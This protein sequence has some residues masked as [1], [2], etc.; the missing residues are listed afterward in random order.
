MALLPVSK[1]LE[2]LLDSAEILSSETVPIGEAAGRVLAEPVQ[3][4]RTQPPFP[5]SAMDGY[6]VRADDLKTIPTDLTVIGEAPAGHGFNGSVGSGEAVRIFTGAPVPDGADAILIQENAENA[7]TNRISAQTE[8][9]EGQHVR[10]AGLDFAKGEDLAEP[11]RLLDAAMLSL[12]AAANHAELNVV[13]RPRVA[14]LATGDELLPPGS[15]P[16]PDQIIASN[17]YGVAAIAAAAGAQTDDLGIVPDQK[18]A[19]SS[20]ISRALEAKADVIVTLGGAS[21][22]DHDL[23]RDVM[24]EMGMTLD[25]WRIAMR[26]GKPLMVGRLKGTHILGLPGNPVSSI[27]CSHLFLVPLLAKLGGRGIQRDIRQATIMT[28]LH[29]NDEREDYIRAVVHNGDNG[30]EAHPFGKQDSSMLKV[31]AASNGLVIRP[32]HAPAI[33][34]GELCDVLMLREPQ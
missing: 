22:G 26:P 29:K 24:E 18:T 27:V 30:L 33:A 15:E 3:A 13:R 14:I 21:V 31:L 2:Q 7:G 1:A 25:F 32:P 34:A 5:A 28:S 4:L 6:A 20:A 11:G 8:V 17:S 19:I 23:V 16:G 10:R 12:A 9:V